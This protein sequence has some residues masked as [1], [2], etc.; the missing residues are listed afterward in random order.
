ML[1]D[2]KVPKEACPRW[3]R[4]LRCATGQP[5]SVRWRGGPQNSLRAL[6]AL[7][8]NSCGQSDHEAAASYG[9]AAHPANA[10]PQAHPQGGGNPRAIAALGPRWV[11]P[12]LDA[13][14]SVDPWK[15]KQHAARFM[16]PRPSAA[17]AR[18]GLPLLA[19]RAQKRSGWG[20]RGQRS[21]PALRALTGRSCLNAAPTARSEFCGSASFA[22]IAGCPA[23]QR[24]GHGQWGRLLLPSFLG[25]ARKEGAPPGGCPGLP[26]S[27]KPTKTSKTIAA[28]ASR[29]SARTLKHL[30]ITTHP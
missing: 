19:G 22:S 4:P 18:V 30:R 3:L 1:H 12:R 25:E 8:S 28:S 26:T 23:A 7:R 2:K 21:M 14:R 17:M 29:V 5:G 24:R 20:A 15:P 6:R 27:I 16:R 9:A 11:A 10:P 13:V